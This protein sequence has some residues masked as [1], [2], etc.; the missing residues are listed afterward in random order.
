MRLVI[1]VCTWGHVDQKV[2]NVFDFVFSNFYNHY[3]AQ[4]PSDQKSKLDTSS[5]C[6]NRGIRT[7]FPI[8]NWKIVCLLVVQI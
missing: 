4:T 3:C 7:A 6:K 5:S 8:K 2:N 1:H